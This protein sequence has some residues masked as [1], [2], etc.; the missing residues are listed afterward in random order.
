[1]ANIVYCATSLDGYIADRDGDLEWLESIPNP[2][3]SDFG[4][5]AFM[6]RIDAL[7]MGRNTFEKVHGFE[8][9]WPYTKPVFVVSSS[10]KKLPLGYEGKASLVS[11]TPRDIV[12]LLHA[13][14]YQELYI[15]GGK[16]I[17][18]FLKED[19]I[20]EMILST[21]PT[22]LGAGIP[23]FGEINTPL[24]FN[25]VKSDVVEGSMVQTHYKRKR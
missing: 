11:G 23:L 7:V 20:D 14:G 9:E 12:S 10:L 25:H 17:Q 24:E 8:C 16:L 19:L 4:F 13:R 15:D 1:M 2:E 6:E 22:I 18:S 3:D 5:G 21:I